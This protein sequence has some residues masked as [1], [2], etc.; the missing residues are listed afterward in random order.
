[1]PTSER[2]KGLIAEDRE[3]FQAMLNVLDDFDEDR[4]KVVR[5]NAAINNILEDF[6]SEKQAISKTNRAVINILED[7]EAEKAKTEALNA[8]LEQRV[9]SRSFE[10]S[11]SQERFR[12]L[13]NG[14][15]DYAIIMLDPS[16][17]I[18][19]WNAGAKRIKGYSD[20]EIIGSHFS[21]FYTSQDQKDDKPASILRNALLHGQSHIE[22][23]QVRKDG[24]KFL[25]EITI[26]AL[27]DDK[28]E[29]RGYGKITR[30]ITERVAAEERDREAFRQEVALKEIHHRVKN[31]LQV[32]SS[33]LFLQSTL[34]DDK[35]TLDILRESQGRV[36][37]IALIHEKL[38]RSNS[39]GKLAFHDYVRDLIGEI[40][41]TYL[42]GQ[43]NIKIHTAIGD[44]NLSIDTAIPCGLIVNELVSNALKHAF[45][46]GRGGDIWIKVTVSQ[47]GQY[48]LTI[49][50]NGI[51]L[52][53][54]HD[55]RKSKS[56]GHRLVA[57]LSRQ[58]DGQATM[59]TDQGTWFQLI[60]EEINYKERA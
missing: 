37:S 59:K 31:N 20:D 10:L 24:S 17:E 47:G 33:L 58:L 18:V 35:A 52:P 36:K 54:G 6:N 28:K 5:T 27:Y 3:I 1:M 42:A 53:A 8:E 26:T 4:S 14:V 13:V 32:V 30:D 29:L 23:W 43:E 60:F 49:Y 57:D 55:W 38:Y 40:T 50:D 21:C 51:G 22:T 7:L 9:T 46:D 25:A 44:M 41:R 39:L 56:L 34:V 48:Q 19:T 45:P 11:L 2:R 16:G 15:E 12:L